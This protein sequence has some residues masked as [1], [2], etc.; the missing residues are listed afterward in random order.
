MSHAPSNTSAADIPDAAHG[1]FAATEGD[2]GFASALRGELTLARRRPVVWV[3]LGVWAACIALFAYLV[4]YLSTVGSQWYTSEQQAMFV[5]A[6]LPQGT[7]YYV[8]ASLPLYGAPQFAILGA[9]LGASDYARGVLGTIVA[10]FAGRAPFMAARL[11]G[12][13]LIAALGAMVTLLASVVSSVGVALAAGSAVSFP[14]LPDLAGAFVAI[15]LV[16]AAFIALGFGIGTLTRRTVVAT[17]IAIIWVLGVE[18]LLVGMLA[19]VV[20][21]LSSVQGYLP[22]GATASLAAAFVPAGQQTLPAVAAATSPAAAVAVLCAWTVAAG[23]VA[24][25][26][27]RQRD[28][29]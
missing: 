3:S 17:I 9:I 21:F 6:M 27:F 18:S 14:P 10:R 4:S 26:L 2:P 25:A 22:V 11:V 5:N 12:L 7:S 19:P 24:Y 8:L 16:A 20:P 23:S 1:R 29:T 15:W 28:L 13:L